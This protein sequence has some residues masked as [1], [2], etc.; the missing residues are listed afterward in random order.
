MHP[1][2]SK[3]IL[4]LYSKPASYKFSDRELKFIKRHE[5]KHKFLIRYCFYRGKSKD[6]LYIGFVIDMIPNGPMNKGYS[7]KLE[8][9]CTRKISDIEY[10]EAIENFGTWNRR[11]RIWWYRD[12]EQLQLEDQKYNIETPEEFVNECIKRGYYGNYQM[13][14]EFEGL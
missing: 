2:V 6:N 1:K 11:F 14:I 8:C 7:N 4:D 9:F 10:Q 13:K 12:I 3:K 5:P